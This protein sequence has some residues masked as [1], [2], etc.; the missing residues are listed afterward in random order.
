MAEEAG[1]GSSVK[2]SASGL[3]VDPG[4]HPSRWSRRVSRI[5]RYLI[6]GIIVL[7][8]SPPTFSTASGDEAL[9]AQNEL[10]LKRIQTILAD[11]PHTGSQRRL[12]RTNPGPG[13]RVVSNPP[14][15]TRAATPSGITE[16]QIDET[17]SPRHHH[18]FQGN[19]FKPL[20]SL[21]PGKHRWRFRVWHNHHLAQDWSEWVEFTVE[22]GALADPAPPADQ[23]FRNAQQSPRPR[24]LPAR[25]RSANSLAEPEN[26]RQ[27]AIVATLL[28]SIRKEDEELINR[29]DFLERY[30]T[31]IHHDSNVSACDREFVWTVSRNL[32]DASAVWVLTGETPARHL[33]RTLLNTLLDL[34]IAGA[35]G[36]E[37]N[38]LC[39]IRVAFYL[40]LAYDLLHDALE[41]E[42]RSKILKVVEIRTNDALDRFI[43]NRHKSFANHHYNSHG[44]RNLAAITAIASVMAKDLPIAEFWFAQ[45]FP[46]LSHIGNPW[47][48]EDGGYGNGLNYAIWDVVD[49]LAKFDTIKHAT[50]WD[51]YRSAHFRQ[52]G[53]FAN[54][55]I[56]PD[57][58]G[59]VFGDG[60]EFFH[61]ELVS[62]LSAM[63]FHRTGD[64]FWCRVAGLWDAPP[65]PAETSD[66]RDFLVG[67]EGL[68]TPTGGGSQADCDFALPTAAVFE[69]AGYAAM[70]AGGDAASVAIFFRASPYGSG[71]HSHAD[72]NSFVAFRDGAP[73]LTQGGLYDQYGSPHHTG[74]TRQT[75]AHNA[76][77]FDGGQGQATGQLDATGQIDRFETVGEVSIVRGSAERAYSGALSVAR[78]TLALLPPD[79]LLVSDILS[80]ETPRRFEWNLH[81]PD[82]F[83][84][85]GNIVRSISPSG[86][87]CVIPLQVP[88]GTA[89]I[90]EG[91]PTPPLPAK[92]DRIPER[93]H[94]R[95]TA[96]AP[97]WTVR[98][99]HLIDFDCRER[100]AVTTGKS[101]NG[102]ITVSLP[103]R[104]LTIDASGDIHTR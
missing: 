45:T 40:A 51:G 96:D 22:S 26:A 79:R 36:I 77:T 64:A 4:T 17:D 14:T 5:M 38:D 89:A 30:R 68:L 25:M 21:K 97:A 66:S 55:F 43:L 8:F 50:G 71:S 37:S 100:P 98:F 1:A 83:E 76:I 94:Y 27:R 44:F 16:L 10:R 54:Y 56:R 34:D 75:A 53:I 12:A 99:V 67:Y 84:E 41:E 90:W 46:L 60:A 33:A 70:R 13:D 74:W 86:V 63:L 95:W 49:L 35:T 19:H 2:V 23:L 6:A 39:N 9:T 11:G 7:A 52:F 72:Q 58:R 61:P 24:A 42:T 59:N 31:H 47:I 69:D 81:S 91:Y 80:S 15:F 29:P 57:V 104:E 78:R 101:D 18:I 93:W 62:A 65:D 73:V 102:S 92:Y 82:P 48:G 85:I 32:L 3:M 88:D 20:R 103:D 28:A 87:T